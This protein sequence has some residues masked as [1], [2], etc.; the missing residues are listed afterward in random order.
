MRLRTFTGKTLHEAMSQVRQ[1]MGHDA[2]I[3]ATHDAPG[4]G[5]EVRAAAERIPLARPEQDAQSHAA[6]RNEDRRKERGDHAEGLTRI[7]RALSYHR[8]SEPAAEAL[9]ESACAF[10]EGEATA[11][12]ARALDA[13]YA[14]HPIEPAPQRPLVF[15]GTPGSGKTSTLA[16]VAARAL[17]H[18][19]STLIIGMDRAAGARERLGAFAHA[20]SCKFETALGP[21]ELDAVMA[22]AEESVI[23]I[24]SPA[25][26]PFDLD[27]L[28]DLRDIALSSE[29]EIILTHE[30]AMGPED[31]EDMAA[32][33]ASIGVARAVITKLDIARRL[34]GLLG[35]GEAGLSY[36]Q[37]SAS[38]F[39][40]SGLA[41]ATPLRL[42]RLLLDDF[43][44][45]FEGI[46][47]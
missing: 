30:A 11:M 4:G 16:K 2:V 1:S 44:S 15:A 7:A 42:S 33:F 18:K 26:N 40:G 3:I 27:Q 14:M 34:G 6:Q 45:P 25:C 8:V 19:N 23:L 36:A 5:V 35:A 32:L 21:H 43:D 29:G 22:G 39:I 28:D 46:S 17:A 31:G 10:E 9:I 47:G 20:M 37:I 24:D 13:R 41:P 38:P 12:L